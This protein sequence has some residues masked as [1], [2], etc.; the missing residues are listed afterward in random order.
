MN[1]QAAAVAAVQLIAIGKDPNT[2]ELT[3]GYP[4]EGRSPV[5]PTLE[6]LTTN[7]CQLAYDRYPWFRPRQFWE[8]LES[9]RSWSFGH[10]SPEVVHKTKIL[11]NLT[12]LEFKRVSMTA[13]H[14][15]RDA[16]CSGSGRQQTR[17]KA[18]VDVDKPYLLLDGKPLPADEVGVRYVSAL[19][20]ANGGR[21]SFTEWV[22][23][24]NQFAGATTTRVL[25][26]LPKEIQPF[27]ER[28]K[29]KPPRLRIALL[30]S[31]Y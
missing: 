5:L 17:L 11:L 26:R 22:R 8:L 19:I 9:I 31:A 21:V 12:V 20:K 18:V 10:R 3:F 23:D 2:T 16:A 30:Q 1:W 25:N 7:F 28:A 29:G 24:K 14:E 4:Q 15:I 13:L 27:I 6:I